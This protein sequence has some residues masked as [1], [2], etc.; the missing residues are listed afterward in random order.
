M[1]DADEE[2]LAR[3]QS[4]VDAGRLVPKTAAHGIALKVAN[5]GITSL[6][7]AQRAVWRNSIEPVLLIPLNDQE[8]F[9]QALR[10]DQRDEALWGDH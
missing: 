8:A 4:H 9:D 3:I 6:S 1:I 5:E 7:P 10:N 2:L